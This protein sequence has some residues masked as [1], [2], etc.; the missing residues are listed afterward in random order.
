MTK[1]KY[2]T[3]G[4]IS[5][6]EAIAIDPVF[7]DAIL[8]NEEYMLDWEKYGASSNDKLKKGMMVLA[9]FNDYR[10]T[11]YFCIC[12]ITSIKMNFLGDMD[13]R[14]SNGLYSWRA[15]KVKVL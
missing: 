11:E 2:T 6:E 12:K 7:A 9:H 15:S 4:S 3:V 14:I 10:G 13:A 1:F 8:K 5:N